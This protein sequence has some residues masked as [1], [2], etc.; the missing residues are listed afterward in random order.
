MVR[1][2]EVTQNEAR[3]DKVRHE[4]MSDML[5]ERALG[6]ACSSSNSTGSNVSRE[7][8][9][10][11]DDGGG[12]EPLLNRKRKKVEA[13]VESLPTPAPQDHEAFKRLF[14]AE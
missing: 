1:V 7:R 4:K 8:D 3:T 6:P 2:E 10:K 5:E 14:P 13:A 11:M 9:D 12:V